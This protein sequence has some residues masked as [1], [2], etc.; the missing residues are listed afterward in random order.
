MV[1]LF[2]LVFT[3]WRF[4][5]VLACDFFIFFF[6]GVKIFQRSKESLL[7]ILEILDKGFILG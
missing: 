2:L 1:C 7:S 4:Q 5:N 3:K 6:A